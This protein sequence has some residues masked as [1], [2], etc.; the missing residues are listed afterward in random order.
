MQVESLTLMQMAKICAALYDY[1][2]CKKLFCIS[3]LTFLTT[4]GVTASFEMSMGIII[5]EA[6]AYIAFAGK[7]VI[8]PVLNKTKDS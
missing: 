1:R 3:I 5:A 4:D 7:K 2:P 6:N 8:E